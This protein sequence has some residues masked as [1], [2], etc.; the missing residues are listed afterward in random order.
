MFNDFVIWYLLLLITL[1]PSDANLCWWTKF[2][3]IQMMTHSSRYLNQR[4]YITDGTSANIYFSE[5][6][7]ECKFFYSTRPLENM[8]F[9]CKFLQAYLVI[10]LWIGLCC[11][12]K[13]ASQYWFRWWLGAIRQPV[14]MVTKICVAIWRYWEVI[15]YMAPSY[16][17]WRHRSTL[18][19]LWLFTGQHQA[20]TWANVDKDTCLHMAF[21][22]SIVLTCTFI[23]HFYAVTTMNAYTVLGVIYC[24]MWFPWC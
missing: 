10:F 13:F 2:S 11:M 22:E 23:C 19:R 15:G 3:L 8:I 21:L 24:V 4:W 6:W 7:I 16:V 18:L 14:P 9:K 20:I 5:I 1:Y 17:T 12:P